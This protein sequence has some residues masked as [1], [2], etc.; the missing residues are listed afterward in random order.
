VSPTYGV[1][2]DWSKFT[3][4]SG[5]T[6]WAKVDLGK[7]AF[8]THIWLSGGTMSI[9]NSSHATD[10]SHYVDS[11]SSH[12]NLIWTTGGSENKNLIPQLL[13]SDND[14]MYFEVN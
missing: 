8:I 13:S 5:T 6:V 2:G 12:S 3:N 10:C 14:V 11:T 4:L 1:G 9:C 7:E